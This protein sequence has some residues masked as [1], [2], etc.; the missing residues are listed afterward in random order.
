MSKRSTGAHM[1][2]C[3]HTKCSRATFR[4]WGNILFFSYRAL[5]LWWGNI[6]PQQNHKVFDRQ[7]ERGNTPTPAAYKGPRAATPQHRASGPT[8]KDLLHPL[9]LQHRTPPLTTNRWSSFDFIFRLSLKWRRPASWLRPSFSSSSSR[10]PLRYV[11]LRQHWEIAKCTMH[12][13]SLISDGCYLCCRE[14]LM[15]RLQ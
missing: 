14:P 6:L 9:T 12:D 1:C 4:V 11:R 10:C 15:T 8:G 13:V 2:R 5:C 3:V 7:L